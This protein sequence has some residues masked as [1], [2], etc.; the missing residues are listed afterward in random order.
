M[1]EK[2]PEKSTTKTIPYLIVLV[3]AMFGFGFLLVPLYD[4]LCDLA[5]INGKVDLVA[6]EKDSDVIVSDRTVNI[7]FI[8]LNNNGMPWIFK[9]MHTSVKAHPGQDYNTSFYASNPT[10]KAMTAQA[11]PS[12]TP[13]YAAK[14]FHKI[15]CFCF[16]QQELEAGKEEEMGLRFVVDAE[17]PDSIHTITLTYTLFDVT[18]DESVASLN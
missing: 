9:P 2:K 8:S 16:D 4:V 11:V 17:I 13:G 10:E 15:E 1:Q 3:V 14:Y 7:Q 6:Y 5:G 18:A 12:I